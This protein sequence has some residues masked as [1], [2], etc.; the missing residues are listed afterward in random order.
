M[1]ENTDIP[2][3]ICLHTPFCQPKKAC[4]NLVPKVIKR[5][6]RVSTNLGSHPSWADLFSTLLT[7]LQCRSDFH[8]YKEL[9][10]SNSVFYVLPR[11]MLDF[12][13]LGVLSERKAKQCF[14]STLRLTWEPAKRLPQ[15]KSLYCR[16]ISGTVFQLSQNTK[17][18][19]ISV[20]HYRR[21]NFPF[22]KLHRNSFFLALL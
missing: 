3:P 6:M 19:L 22:V 7:S 18:L 4:L 15:T 20:K 9:L 10:S 1:A 5:S 2:N 8:L 21:H 11:M 13:V 12:M 17:C 16:T 14:N